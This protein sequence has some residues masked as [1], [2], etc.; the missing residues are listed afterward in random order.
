LIVIGSIYGIM[1]TAWGAAGVVGPTLIAQVRQ[2]TGQ[3]QGALR[4]MALITLLSAIA[5]LVL[6]PPVLRRVPSES[7]SDL[8]NV[9]RR[10]AS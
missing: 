6:H 8:A 1:L 10:I 2:A 5:P 3:Y 9:S 4:M 7:Q